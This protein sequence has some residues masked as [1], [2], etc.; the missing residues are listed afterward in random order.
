[1]KEPTVATKQKQ[2]PHKLRKHHAPPV[3]NPDALLLTTRA[4]ALKLGCSEHVVRKEMRRAR[5]KFIYL[6]NRHYAIRPEWLD[7]YIE[8]RQ[9]ECAVAA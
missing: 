8:Q 6:G 5:L 1:M 4:A 2:K 7:E 9:Q 3:L